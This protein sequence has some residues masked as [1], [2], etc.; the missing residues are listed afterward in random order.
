MAAVGKRNMRIIGVLEL[1]GAVGLVL[2]AV[3]G[4]LPLLTPLAAAMFALLMAFAIVFH[5]RRPGEV[6]NIAFNVIL[7]AVA[8]AVAYG[9]FVLEPF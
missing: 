1:L 6:S 4:I 7:G 9:R 8:L 5:A 3:T 2:P